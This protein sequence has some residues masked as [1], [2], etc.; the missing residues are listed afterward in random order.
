MTFI[1]NVHDD[2]SFDLAALVE[3]GQET[4]SSAFEK[5]YKPRMETGKVGLLFYTLGGDA[6]KFSGSYDLT[7]GAYRRLGIVADAIEGTGYEI[8]RSRA[9]LDDLPNEH[10]RKLVLT[11]EGALPIGQPADGFTTLHNFYNLGLRSICLFWFKANQVGDG[12]SEKRNGGLTNFGRDVVAEM[13]RIG[14]LVDI[15]QAAPQSA[16]DVLGLSTAPVIASHSNASGLYEHPRNLTD[17]EARQ[18]AAG[19]GLIGVS[20]YPAHIAKVPTLGGL[21]DHIDYLVE[22]IGPEHVCFGLNIL[23]STDKDMSAFFKNADIEFSSLWLED[24]EDIT[25]M[26]NLLTGMEQRGHD[27]EVIRKVAGGNVLRVLREVLH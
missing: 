16:A 12:I 9:D 2:L 4:P 26:N 13:N 11:M 10:A 15:S 8:V 21:L 1:A 20:T 5:M 22:L 3:S 7:A 18:V 17:D 23:P 24:L 19:G 6:P 14:M 25:K 27:E